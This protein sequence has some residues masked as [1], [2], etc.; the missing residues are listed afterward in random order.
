MF[1]DA[2]IED[3]GTPAGRL[4]ALLAVTEHR[5]VPGLHQGL[6]IGLTGFRRE[7]Q[8]PWPTST[9]QVGHFLTAVRLSFDARFLAFPLFGLALGAW[10]ARD[11]PLR[12]IIGHEKKPDPPDASKIGIGTLLRALR[13]F[14]QQ[15]QS[16]ADE[17]VVNFQ[18]GNLDAIDVGQ[19]I[20]NSMADLRLSHKG[21]H[22]GKTIAAG[23]FQSGQ[24]VAEWIRTELCAAPDHRAGSTRP[25]R[26]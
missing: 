26:E 24:Q 4:R 6:M 14:R 2:G 21:W 20:G 12:L 25:E 9:D 7:F 22:F 11:V 10:G 15:Y 8:D 17:D 3:D 5:Y 23:Q 1:V 13:H 16:T 19:G 18:S